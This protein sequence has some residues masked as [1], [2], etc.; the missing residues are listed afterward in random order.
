MAFSKITSI[1]SVHDI[2]R[3]PE[4]A[5]DHECIKGCV[6]IKCNG[7]L[8]VC[9]LM[10]TCAQWTPDPPPKKKKKSK[11]KKSL[12]S[13]FGASTIIEEQIEDVSIFCLVFG[14]SD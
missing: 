4:D 11:A 13:G 9:N 8:N 3:V 10:V 7:V 14:Q 12:L 2:F 6:D 5:T 1:Q